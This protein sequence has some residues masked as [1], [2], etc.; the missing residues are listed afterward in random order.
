MDTETDLPKSLS[1]SDLPVVLI[2]EDEPLI[3]LDIETALSSI[4]ASIRT[5]ATC[6]EA[7]AWLRTHTPSAAI[8][9]IALV[10][11]HCLA[12]AKHLMTSGIPFIVHT[13]M[14]RNEQ[15]DEV[16]D[17]GIWMSKPTDHR[18]LVEA[19]RTLLASSVTAH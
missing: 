12:V 3:A 14:N 19:V 10:D 11:G 16:F 13:V 4:R 15:H 18:A 2:L 6:S 8:L 17:A 7:E 1:L 5:A 9:D